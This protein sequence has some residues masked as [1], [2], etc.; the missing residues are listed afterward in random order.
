MDARQDFLIEQVKEIEQSVKEIAREVNSLDKTIGEYKVAFD[1]HVS[2]DEDMHNELK[3]MNDIL[4]ANTESLKL[5][6]RRTELLEDL[7]TKI[8]NRLNTLEVKIIEDKA[9][10][11]YK[12][13]VWVNVAKVVGILVGVA[14]LV[15]YLPTL[16]RLILQ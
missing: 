6:M 13:E 7:S 4:A 11:Q 5:H 2:I 1:N 14:T 16:L 3:R 9:V 15:A 8:D 12:K 10:S